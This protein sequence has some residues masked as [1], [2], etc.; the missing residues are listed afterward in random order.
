MACKEILLKAVVQAVPTYD[1]SC[2]KL[3]KKLIKDHRLIVISGG[4][5]RVV[6]V[7]C[8]GVSETRC[9]LVKIEVVLGFMI[10]GALTKLFWQ[11]KGGA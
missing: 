7:K 4:T 6:K 8:I 9:V 2:F 10:L 1:M 3:S 5:L 11:S